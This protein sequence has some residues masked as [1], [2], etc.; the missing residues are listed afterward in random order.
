MVLS[1]VPKTSR[2]ALIVSRTNTCGG[3]NKSGLPSRI[4]SVTN[5]IVFSCR[6]SC[7][8]VPKVCVIS[9][10]ILMNYRPNHKY[11]G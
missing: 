5:R 1:N 10:P 6:D 3:D 11:L 4:G 9:K 8:R 7:Y 2:T